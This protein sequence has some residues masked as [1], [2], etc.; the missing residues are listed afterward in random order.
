MAHT[1]V[2]ARETDMENVLIIGGSGCI[3]TET[4][5]WLRKYKPEAKVIC[6]SRGETSYEAIDGVDYQIGDIRDRDSLHRI[7]ND[8]EI[9]QVMHAAALRTTACNNDPQLAEDINIKGS[10]NVF[11]AAVQSDCVKRVVFLSTA[12]VYDQVDTQKEQVCEDHDTRGYAPYVYSKLQGEKIAQ[13]ISSRANID[14]VVLR[15][16]ILFG[17]SR[18]TEG[19]TAGIT[20]A[21]RAGAK[22]ES[23]E[24][25]FSGRYSFHFTGDVGPLIAGAL[26][27]HMKGNFHILNLPGK[28]ISVKDIATRINE[29]SDAELITIK[30]KQY[31]FAKSISY[32]QYSEKIGPVLLT[33]F[34]EA[35]KETLNFFKENLPEHTEVEESTE[36]AAE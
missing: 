17:P 23:Y 4:I 3:G 9:T 34:K 21:L 14:I 11:E 25:P 7:I 12:A 19:S 30:D 24:I 16:Q 29:Y 1:L 22:G 2:T 6:L 28:S 5:K 27:N 35:I 10:E 15:P 32:K 36:E 13:E 20:N 26:F 33:G 31:P 18:G 8:N